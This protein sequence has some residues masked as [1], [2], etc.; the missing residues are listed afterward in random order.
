[1]HVAVLQRLTSLFR[2]LRTERGAGKQDKGEQLVKSVFSYLHRCFG[3]RPKDHEGIHHQDN[4][5][6]PTAGRD[7]TVRN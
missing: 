1:M 5:M 4:I 6:H 3:L 7:A 2:L